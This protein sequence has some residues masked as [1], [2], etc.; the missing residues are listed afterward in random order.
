MAWAVLKAGDGVFQLDLGNINLA[1]GEVKF[2]KAGKSMETKSN[3]GMGC[4]KGRSPF[5]PVLPPK[6]EPKKPPLRKVKDEKEDE[7][8]EDEEEDEQE[9]EKDEE[10]KKPAPKKGQVRCMLKF[11]EFQGLNLKPN[12]SGKCKFCLKKLSRADRCY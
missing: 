3:D 4:P 1:K 12:P 5:K 7:E 8:E 10:E 9:E 2:V 11:S 6:P